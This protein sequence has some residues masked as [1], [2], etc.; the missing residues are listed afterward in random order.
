MTDKIQRSVDYYNLLAVKHERSGRGPEQLKVHRELAALVAQCS[1]LEEIQ[2]RMKAE[3]YLEKPAKAL[4]MDKMWNHA[5][6]ARENDLA[7]VAEV[8]EQK[9]ED[10]KADYAKAHETGWEQEV[11]RPLSDMNH[12]M[13]VVNTLAGTYL[14]LIMTLPE[15]PNYQVLTGKIQKS[16]S[17]LRNMTLE[18]ALDRPYIRK[19][20][21]MDD[22]KYAAFRSTMLSIAQ[23]QG[24]AP[25]EDFSGRISETLQFVRDNKS[26]LKEVHKEFEAKSKRRGVLYIA[27]EEPGPYSKEVMYESEN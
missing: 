18:Q 4:Y 26:K 5:Q 8:Y 7:E 10:V 15:N 24:P 13:D 9:Y 14:E 25:S 27:A 11:T 1:A 20:V 23:N 3:G 2:E 17:D 12:N 19:H 21:A 22:S 16:A 6:A